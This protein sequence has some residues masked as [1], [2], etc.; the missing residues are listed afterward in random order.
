[1]SS[2][3]FITKEKIIDGQYSV[4]MDLKGLFEPEGRKRFEVGFEELKKSCCEGIDNFCRLDGHK[5]KYKSETI[6]PTDKDSQKRKVLIVFGNPAI[7]SIKNGMFFFSKSNK[8]RHSMSGR[9][10]RCFFAAK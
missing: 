5:L 4:S 2:D 10:G 6:L 7:H 1:M 3:K 9:W 8:Q